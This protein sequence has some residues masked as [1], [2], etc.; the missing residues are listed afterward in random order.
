MQLMSLLAYRRTIITLS[1]RTTEF[2]FKRDSQRTSNVITC[3]KEV[4]APMDRSPPVPCARML[5]SPNY[6]PGSP[7][8]RIIKISDAAEGSLTPALCASASSSRSLR[9]QIRTTLIK[10]RVENIPMRISLNPRY[11]GKRDTTHIFRPAW[12]YFYL[13]CK[14]RT[15]QLVRY[16]IHRS[17]FRWGDFS[18]QSSHPL[19]LLFESQHQHW[20]PGR[21]GQPDN[22]SP[23]SFTQFSTKRGGEKISL[24]G[25]FLSFFLF[26][27]QASTKPQNA[28]V[29]WYIVLLSWI[30]FHLQL[31]RPRVGNSHKACWFKSMY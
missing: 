14:T 2:R 10:E 4:S 5:P 30:K 28:S 25:G 11:T 24:L 17:Q 21:H 6:S 12:I 15:S 19:H 26:F 27:K 1:P 7:S 16:R 9:K 3:S 29:L 13:L 31:T 18:A 23:Q 8:Q 20:H 22:P